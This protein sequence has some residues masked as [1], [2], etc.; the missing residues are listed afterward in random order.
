MDR[1]MVAKEFY[2]QRSVTSDVHAVHLPQKLSLPTRSQAI[3]FFTSKCF[4]R[5]FPKDVTI[6]PV[7]SCWLNRE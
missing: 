7:S 1:G 5:R 6:Y 3:G 4:L 2:L